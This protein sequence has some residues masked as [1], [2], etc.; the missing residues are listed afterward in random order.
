MKWVN[1]VVVDGKKLSGNL[2]RTN[3][4]A[5]EN[6][7]VQI[8]IGVNVMVAPIE[9]STCVQSIAPTDYN[10]EK[11]SEELLTMLI[12]DIDKSNNE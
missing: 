12:K 2:V 3:N 1:D 8:G 10:V 11:L 7:A 9:G 4:L 5:E 6:Y